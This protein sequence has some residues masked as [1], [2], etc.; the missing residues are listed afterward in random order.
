[1]SPLTLGGSWRGLLM[2]KN[3]RR[4][5]IAN[6]VGR[7]V[8]AALALFAIP[9]TLARLGPEAYGLVGLSLTLEALFAFLDFGLSTAMN[10]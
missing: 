8:P 1:V 4:N 2:G 7:V 6:L 10:R 5:T 9:I 3:L